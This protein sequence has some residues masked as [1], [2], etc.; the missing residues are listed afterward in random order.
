MQTQTLQEKFYQRVLDQEQ[1]KF[2]YFM[3][4]LKDDCQIKSTNAEAYKHQKTIIA[5][6]GDKQKEKDFLGYEFSTRKGD[7]GIKINRNAQAQAINKMYD[8]NDP[9]NPQKVN[10]YILKH[11]ENEP[12]DA[13]DEG[14]QEHLKIATLSDMLDFEKVDFSNGLNLNPKINFDIESQ[15]ELVKL[16]EIISKENVVNG[17][18]FKSSNLKDEKLNE[19][20]LPVLKIGNI[21]KEQ[22]LVNFTNDN[23]QYHISQNHS[24][25]ICD[26]GYLSI[27]LT[28]ATVGKSG[29][30]KEKCLLNQRVL[31][32]KNNDINLKFCSV[33]ILSHYFYQYAQEFSFG[34]AQGN[35]SPDQAL[36]FK[37]P[38]PPKAI[39]EQIV[40]ECEAVDQAKE[41]AEQTIE[42][43]KK[44]IEQ[45]VQQVINAGYAM[46]KLEKLAFINPPKSEIKD[47]EGSTLVSFIE[48]S[49]VSNE[50]FIENKVDKSL[51]ELKKG[52]YTYFKENDILI[53]KITP[54]MENGKCAIATDLTNA[55]GMGSSEFHIIRCNDKNEID[56]KF[57]FKVLNREEVRNNAMLNMT[58][59]SG[60]RRV[61]KSF[62]ENLQIPVPP[63]NI[64]K[65]LIQK[66]EKLEQKINDAKAIADN[67]PIQK[68]QILKKHL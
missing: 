47:I 20:Y 34:N 49:S 67:A 64:Q 65:N 53:A 38:L 44:E 23:T 13:I 25:K 46:K 16:G 14:L 7:E 26:K 63:L 30:V 36:D 21:I 33:F 60:H 68:E 42:E 51:E 15:W 45:K 22:S 5:H 55:I 61:P 31:A 54:C 11:F 2:Y 52:S 17:Y 4:T 57:V 41:K 37:I 59:S 48:M 9:F 24:S 1:E 32:I 6:S 12:F 50:G 58:G 29:W 3:L 56:E 8:D 28:G 27:A 35:L 18:A 40:K 39:Q 10:S 66:V 62:Y 43:A 19:N